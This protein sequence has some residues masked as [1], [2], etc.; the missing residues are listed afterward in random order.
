MAEWTVPT[1]GNHEAFN[2][3][4]W[5]DYWHG[6]PD[7]D[8]FVFAGVRFLNQNS[9]CGRIP[10]GY[11]VDGPQYAFV[12]STLGEN[13]HACVVAFWHRPVLSAVAGAPAME[14]L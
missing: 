12:H 8:T 2:L 4:A 10:D 7:W 9:E 5:R 14:P 1:L 6:R 11:G 3:A 13:T